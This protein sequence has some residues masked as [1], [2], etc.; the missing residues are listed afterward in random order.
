MKDI[1]TEFGFQIEVRN[2]LQHTVVRKKFFTNQFD[3]EIPTGEHKYRFGIIGKNGEVY[4]W[5]SWSSLADNQFTGL[6]L[7]PNLLEPTNNHS[8]DISYTDSIQ[9][10]WTKID[11]AIFY[12]F[13][14]Y[15][16][17]T[18]GETLVF[19]TEISKNFITLE[20][21]DSLSEGKFTW[22]VRAVF[23]KESGIKNVFNSNRKH[24][25][26]YLSK[27]VKFSSPEDLIILSPKNQFV[28]H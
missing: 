12:I 9:F 27:P 25:Y 14:I 7:V 28:D 15:Q 19:Q 8:L 26:L 13:E 24:F 3:L 11:K 1:E 22:Q 4:L 17:R 21:F 18:F 2:D 6:F 20:Q 23:P 10:K 16:N 5:S